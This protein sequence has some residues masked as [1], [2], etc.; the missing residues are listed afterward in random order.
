L[1][2]QCNYY[3]RQPTDPIL[4]QIT[5]VHNLVFVLSRFRGDYRRGVDKWMDLLTT[6][7][8][9]SELQV[10]TALEVVSAL[11][12]LL[13]AVSSGLQCLQQPFPSNNFLTVET[14]QLLCSR[15]D[16][17]ANIPQ[18][19][20]QLNYGATSSHKGMVRSDMSKPAL[21]FFLTAR[22]HTTKSTVKIL[23]ANTH[24][25]YFF[26]NCRSY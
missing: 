8:R 9:R 13:H 12:K 22:V 7:T 26:K 19:N 5:A 11:Y 10:I 14:P 1:K 18:L 4:R 2:I 24:C 3:K 21:I 20:C 6:Y 15:R 16:S 23:A 25:K 17:P